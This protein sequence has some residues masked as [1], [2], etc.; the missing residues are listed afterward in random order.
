VQVLNSIPGGENLLDLN[1]GFTTP[2]QVFGYEVD[3]ESMLNYANARYYMGKRGKATFNS[4]DPMW[5]KYPHLS[6]YNYCGNNP[7]MLIDPTGM[8]AIETTTDYYD[9]KGNLLYHTDDGLNDVVIVSDGNIP[10]LKQELQTAKDNGT[11]NDP[12]TNKN[13]MHVLGKTPQQYTDE[14]IKNMNSNWATGYKITYEEAYKE[15]KSHFSIGQIFAGMVAEIARQNNDNS[16]S[17]IHGGRA[18]GITEGNSDRKNGK[19]NRLNPLSSL[20]NNSPLIIVRDRS[21]QEPVNC[22]LKNKSLPK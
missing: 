13:K 10:T 9:T 18:A 14:A 4:T 3:N 16:G 5:Y 15:G 17:E 12:E 7:I 2:Y 21:K 1:N 11:I 8:E 22:I 20:K 19:I 6:P